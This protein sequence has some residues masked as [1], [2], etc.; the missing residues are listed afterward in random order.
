MSATP[1][2]DPSAKQIPIQMIYLNEG[3]QGLEIAQVNQS[4]TIQHFES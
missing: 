4:R 2:T 3:E 1:G